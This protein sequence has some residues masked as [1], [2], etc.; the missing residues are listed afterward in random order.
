MLMGFLL[1]FAS[2]S[3]AYWLLSLDWGDTP[4]EV[5]IGEEY[6]MEFNAE[7]WQDDGDFYAYTW[8]VDIC[9]ESES[10]GTTD[11]TIS[12]FGV[13]R[14]GSNPIH[15]ES[16]QSHEEAGSVSYTASI[17]G[18]DGS[19]VDNWWLHLFVDVV[20]SPIPPAPVNLRLM[21]ATESSITVVWDPVIHHGVPCSNYAIYREG[22]FPGG[23]STCDYVNPVDPDKSIY[24]TDGF[25]YGEAI[26]GETYTFTVYAFSDSDYTPSPPS[27]PLSVILG[28]FDAMP[29]STPTGLAASNATTTGFTLSWAPST[30]NAEVAGYEVRLNG[31]SINGGVTEPQYSFTGLQPDVTYSLR[32]RAYDAAGNYS[33]WSDSL[34]IRLMVFDTELPSTPT[35]LVASNATL[36]AF[37]LSWVPS[38]DNVG[39][40]GYEV[41]L[42]GTS[43][44]GT[45]A[46]LLFSFTGLQPNTT[47]SLE[48]RARDMAGNYSGWSEPLLMAL[49]DTEL[50]SIPNVWDA[51]P[52]DITTTSFILRWMPSTDN[53]G[54][55]GYEVRKNGQTVGSLDGATTQITF[56]GLA[57]AERSEVAVRARDAAGNWSAWSPTVSRKT[58]AGTPAGPGQ[59]PAEWAA[60]YNLDPTDPYGDAD[61]DGLTNIEELN[62]GT[63]P[64]QYD[65]TTSLLGNSVPA[66]WTVLT[67]T[68]SATAPVVG[69]TEGK[70]S[71]DKNGAATYSIPVF[72]VPGTAGMQPEISLNYNSQSKGGIAGYGW[73]LGGLS[74]ITRGPKTLA[75]D[76]MVSGVEFSRED[77]YYLDGQRLVRM[78]GSAHSYAGAEYRLEHDNLT[79]VV[80]QGSTG[81]GPESFKVWTKAGRVMEYGGT[82]PSRLR[83][84]SVAHNQEVQTWALSKV[85]DSAGNYMDFIYEKNQTDGE[86]YLTR[87]NHTGNA[88]AGLAP[89]ASLRFEYGGRS[90]STFG[91]VHG[92]K[93]S[94]TQ[95]LSSISAYYGEVEVRTL[96]CNYTTPV[97]GE[98]SLLDSITEFGADGKA[99]PPLTFAY[100]DPEDGWDLPGT[101]W[102]PPGMV[103][104]PGAFSHFADVNGDGYPDQIICNFNSVSIYLNTPA[105]WVLADGQGGRP[106]FPL[107]SGLNDGMIKFVDLNGDGAADILSFTYDNTCAADAFIKTADGVAHSPEWSIPYHYTPTLNDTNGYLTRVGSRVKGVSFADVNGD[108]Y[109]DCIIKGEAEFESNG[110]S[111]GSTSWSP[112]TQ[113][114]INRSGSMMSGQVSRWQYGNNLFSPPLDVNHLGL[115]IDL[116]GDSIPDFCSSFAYNGALHGWTYVY[117][118][119]TQTWAYGDNIGLPAPLSVGSYAPT[120]AVDLNNDG[121]L[122]IVSSC[123][124]GEHPNPDMASMAGGGEWINK[125]DGSWLRISA[126]GNIY[127]P[128]CYYMAPVPLHG[129][130]NGGIGT[131]LV[132][133]TN[134]GKVDYVCAPEPGD[135]I[136]LYDGGASYDGP[137][138]PYP[139]NLANRTDYAYAPTTNFSASEFVDINADGAIDQ[140]WHLG[141]RIWHPSDPH[142]KGAA[143]NK[144]AHPDRLVSVTNGLGVISTVTYA[145]LTERDADG[146]PTVYQKDFTPADPSDPDP[147]RNI[148][149]PLHV[150]KTLT[151][152][153]PVGD[154]VGA[155]G[156]YSLEYS[157]GGMR[158]DRLHGNLGFEWMSVRDTRTDI[159]TTTV[160]SQ[161]YPTIGKPIETFSKADGGAGQTL[162][163]SSTEYGSIAFITP[164]GGSTSFIFAKSST[165]SAY[166]LDGTLLSQA[167]TLTDPAGDGSGY[168]VYGNCLVSVSTSGTGAD[169]I[170]TVTTGSYANTAGSNQ[171]LL[172]RLTHATVTTSQSG[173]SITRENAFTYDGA[174]GL[175]TSETIEPGHENDPANVYSHTAYTLDAFGN[176]LTAVV[177]GAGIA[178]YSSTTAYDSTGRF[179]VALTNAAGHTEARV[180]DPAFGVPV[181]TTDANGLTTTWAYDGFGRQ[182]QETRADGTQTVTH[183]R[184]APANSGLAGA[185]YV[186]ETESSG[187]APAVAVFDCWGRAVHALALNPDGVDSGSPSG[188]ARIVTTRTEYDNRGLAVRSWLPAYFGDTAHPAVIAT[189]TTY[190]ILNRP[191][192]I[193]KA[194]DDA[195]GGVVDIYYDYEGR[196]IKSTDPAGREEWL[197]ND[198]H[199][200]TVRRVNNA[201]ATPGSAERGEVL[202]DYDP[203]GNL[204]A[205]HVV[206]ENGDA[207]TTTL[208]YDLLGRRTAMD[209]PDVGTWSYAYDALGRVLSQTD[210]KAQAVTMTYDALGRMV[211]RADADSAT[212][213]AY[214][215]ADHGIGQLHTLTHTAANESPYSEEFIYD[216]LSRPVTHLRTIAGTTYSTGQ[217]Y[218]SY[219]RPTVTRYPS[220][221]KVT[222]V[223]DGLG[224]LKEVREA[225]GRITVAPNEVP[226]DHRFWQAEH[227]TVTGS[228]DRASLGNGLTHDRVISTVTGRVKAITSSSLLGGPCVQHQEYLHDLLGQV[229]Q[230]LDHALGLEETFAYDGLNRLTEH[231]VAGSGGTG[232]PPVDLGTVTVAYDALGNITG[233][234]DAGDYAY[235][236]ARPHAVATINNGPLGAQSYAYDANGNLT[237]GAGRAYLWTAAN[238]VRQITQGGQWTRFAFD[239]D[240]QRVTQTREDGTVTIYVGEEFE[241]VEHPGGL[242]EEKHY[243]LTPLGRAAVRTVR[244]DGGIET[245]YFHSDGLGTTHAVTDEWG[246]VEKRF[247]YDAWGK[248]TEVSDTHATNDGGRVTRGFTDHEMLDDFDLIHMNARLYD[249]AIGRFISADRVVQ[250]IGNSQTYNRYSYCANNPVNT[251]D[252]TGNE[253]L[254]NWLNWVWGSLSDSTDEVTVRQKTEVNPSKV[255]QSGTAPDAGVAGAVSNADASSQTGSVTNPNAT[256]GIA[257]AGTQSGTTT[258]GN[259]APNNATGNFAIIL[260][261]TDIKDS[262]ATSLEG[263]SEKEQKIIRNNQGIIREF[264]ILIKQENHR[265]QKN[266][267]SGKVVLDFY[268][269]EAQMGEKAR[270]L[271]GTDTHFS[272]AVAHGVFAKENDPSS[273]L[274]KVEVG[275]KLVDAESWRKILRDN[276]KLSDEHDLIIP[277]HCDSIGYQNTNVI[278]DDLKLTTDRYINMEKS[279]R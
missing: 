128:L 159:V 42:N 37:T 270:Q 226:A 192:L 132:D 153:V 185:V 102:A 234:S 78:G 26:L 193:T 151:H 55:T 44:N 113:L 278:W 53:V 40:A 48:V 213:W 257:G 35:G 268:S 180:Y 41:R 9:R 243:I 3:Q 167:A 56:T 217:E 135:E 73:S 176:R 189:E 80:A 114:W 255:K 50:P 131:A 202:Y 77:Q 195:V 74:T 116:N 154:T 263:K 146:N 61:G 251:F 203:L 191:V 230:R 242:I 10:V 158:A 57:P 142:V 259:T 174:T 138:L 166:N 249:P 31:T 256:Q 182:I 274:H 112:F 70:L 155:S 93:F 139:L 118:A 7:L 90:D 64:T 149:S 208:A 245:R 123:Y 173:S 47:Y 190:D 222:N 91:Y 235:D 212:T 115:L 231:T 71:V 45:V 110:G 266:G 124:L 206:R 58:K 196:M 175:L 98:R 16:L 178:A 229:T 147:K 241:R 92:A 211:T 106:G 134:D 54:V 68:D 81:N 246:G 179:P 177:S 236:A 97:S 160:F 141:P 100:S 250:D 269:S 254:E 4:D 172:G 219:N 277:L 233:K 108:G 204:V 140:V 14:I 271:I 267:I 247:Y 148:I 122:D 33:G 221:F 8:G 129:G 99:Y 198:L 72:T 258:T 150:V 60:Y 111:G 279:R 29:P 199:G 276:S 121:L 34:T 107:P 216:E 1:L 18:L 21:A 15:L 200:R 101:E 105:G 104:Y 2:S 272:A 69:M 207:V 13:C 194:D 62:R 119:S 161:D 137:E 17:Y 232:V 12:D 117:S 224:F 164:A 171:W 11:D 126:Y 22:G 120:E 145:P 264:N 162:S 85:S 95:R 260:V 43:V 168:D 228:I 20:E 237:A 83:A 38:T 152:S 144:R 253:Y 79:R 220:N 30:D 210:A 197:E 163:E 88:T 24:Y 240:R 76:G 51:A 65:S 127:A 5:T 214:D 28:N 183:Y 103:N 187:G 209:D 156:N 225:G 252:P 39:V 273:F 36:T 261:T 248:Q 75:L 265:L 52:N 186:V 63:N 223:Y 19:Y 89:Y 205:T 244:N 82:E 86:Q 215:T 262:A 275:E 238:K 6:L 181:S 184:W 218:D 136:Y 201:A 84:N 133:I 130:Y 67:G 165:T 32:V 59:L 125:G 188:N 23:G 94:T 96:Q 49:N 27:A 46:G 169:A 157:Y 239:A 227:W 109:I 66:G 25:D 87:I 143:L 170:T